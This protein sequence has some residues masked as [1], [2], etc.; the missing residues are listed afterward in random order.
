M[1][2]QNQPLH[3]LRKSKYIQQ[4]EQQL[5]I[6]DMYK[7]LVKTQ[8]RT[9]R[10]TRIC[11]GDILKNVVVS[12]GAG[13]NTDHLKLEFEYAV[14]LSQDC[15]LEQDFTERLGITEEHDKH[16]ETI[17]VCPAYVIDKFSN[18]D[19]VSF[20]I[21]GK[22]SSRSM[23][24]HTSKIINRI[25][26]NDTYKRYHYLAEDLE[27][28]VPGLIIDFKHFVAASRQQLYKSRVNQYV[29]TNNELYRE[30]LSLRFANY[31]GRI[32]LP[33]KNSS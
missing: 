21:E 28:G 27:N 17:L 29:T 9:F 23:Q 19:H 20:M 31:L 24:K 10:K 12:I 30:S 15:D 8:Y 4:N 26:S 32:G 5:V 16:I 6:V 2:L 25:K 7:S 3:L 33:G 18:G 22:P 13:T 1:E 11:Q 14:V